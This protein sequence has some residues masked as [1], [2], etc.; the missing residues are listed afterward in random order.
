[1]TEEELD[2]LARSCRA[3][4]EHAGHARMSTMLSWTSRC[5]TAE[6]LSTNCR[7][8]QGGPAGLV[9]LTVACAARAL[10]MAPKDLLP[11]PALFTSVQI[12]SVSHSVGA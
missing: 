10:A 8:V 2:E 9:L 7:P 3:P 11:V 6:Q 1:M 12:A 5:A 4:A